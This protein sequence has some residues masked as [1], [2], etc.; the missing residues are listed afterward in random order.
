M[1]AITETF[2]EYQNYLEPI[3]I[4]ILK[5]VAPV[6]VQS[7]SF[8]MRFGTKPEDAELYLSQKDSMECG[9]RRFRCEARAHGNV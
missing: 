1:D 2:D 8:V 6:G 9:R 4:E 3:G 5:E 7:G